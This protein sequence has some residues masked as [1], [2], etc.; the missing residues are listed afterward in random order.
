MSRRRAS[1]WDS[2]QP[3]HGRDASHVGAQGRVLARSHLPEERHTK[4]DCGCQREVDQNGNRREAVK[5]LFN[6]YAIAGDVDQA[7]S[8][9]ERWSEKE[10]LDA[11]ALTARADVAARAG[12]RESAHPNL[13]SVVDV[14]PDDVASQKR[15][16]R[17]ERW[18]GRPA[19]GCRHSLAI[20][21]LRRVTRACSRKQRAAGAAT[22]ESRNGGR[23]ARRRRHRE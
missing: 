20:A 22:G 17:L 7:R 12:D 1:V 11:E 5:K 14:R 6:L 9:A 18:A 10:P 3:A 8:V 19:V 13:G 21:Q 23:H 15:L 4:H 2:W 16:A